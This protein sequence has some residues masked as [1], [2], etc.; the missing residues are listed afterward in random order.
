MAAITLT[1]LLA[2]PARQIGVGD[3]DPFSAIVG[4]LALSVSIWAGWLSARA[5]RLQEA[6]VATA[7]ALLARAVAETEQDA[8][9]KMLGIHDRTIDVEFDLLYATAHDVAG[10]GAAGHLAEVVTYYEELRPRR[11]VITG[12]PG[13]GKTLLAV[14]LMLGLLENRGPDAPVPVRISAAS[15]DTDQ[16]VEG[17]ISAHLVEVYRVPAATAEELVAARQ[18]LPVVDGLDEM[19]SDSPLAFNSRA[20]QIL[21]KLNAYQHGRSKAEVILSCRSAHYEMLR[22]VDVWAQ[23]AARVEIRPVSAVKTREFLK[24]RVT[25]LSRWQQVLEKIDHS[26][27]GPLAIS[28]STP[29]RLTLA[30]TIYEQRNPQSGIYLYSPTALLD[31]DLNTVEAIGDHLLS[32]FIP[33]A[34]FIHSSSKGSSYTPERVHVWLAVLASYLNHNAITRRSIAGRQL[35][36]VDI[37]LHD[38]WPLAGTRLPRVVHSV[39]IIGTWSVGAG[40]V[41]AQAPMS[42][43]P[44]FSLAATLWGLATFWPAFIAWN[45]VW[46]QTTRADLRRVRT[47]SGMR[48]LVSGLPVGLS[49]GVVAGCGVGV[50]SD[51]A[52]GLVVG[53]A[54][55]LVA[56]ISAG[57]AAPGAIGTGDPRDMVRADLTFGLTFGLMVG[58]AT[59]LTAGVAGLVGGIMMTV[60]GAVLGGVAGKEFGTVTSGAIFGM[61]GGGSV[62]LMG[63]VTAEHAGTLAGVLTSFLA[64]GCTVGIGGGP[65]LGLAGGLAGTR[66]IALLLCTR[67]LNSQWLPWRLGRFLT[68]CYRA[69]LI[70]IAGSGYQFRHRE[71]QDYLARNPTP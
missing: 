9:S 16:S 21:R 27:T 66:Y 23:D 17:W 62:T 70:R 43:T 65:V 39:L 37:V 40:A 25:D 36:S 33:A 20:A 63:V 47:L 19:D 10:A 54:T 32:L 26:P 48:H 50:V 8:R 52:S 67:R 71:L 4:V 5:L 53:L 44:L 49:G 64:A 18:V 38:L 51:S 30:V 56:G 24:D 3:V 59:G 35:S 57:L 14:E 46:P 61:A 12:P 42:T 29:W 69:E 11:L 41:L 7:T 1:P 2:K 45:D 28:L 13:A 15:W 60:A 68:W 34:T 58:L 6:D 31:G 22:A 55:A